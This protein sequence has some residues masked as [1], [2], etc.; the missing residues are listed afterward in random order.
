MTNGLPHR[1]RR[2]SNHYKH[3]LTSRPGTEEWFLETGQL[4]QELIRGAPQTREILETARSL[5][6]QIFLLQAIRQERRRLLTTPPPPKLYEELSKLALFEE[7]RHEILYGN[8]VK[9]APDRAW[10][11]TMISCAQ[12]RGVVNA[13][14]PTSEGTADLLRRQPKALQ[15]IDVYERKARSRIKKLINRLDYLVIEEKRKI[16]PA[17]D[18]GT[19]K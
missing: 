2:P 15:R 9:E 11:R 7:A 5:S 12:Y 6:G 3:G 8:F 14:V 17:S 10:A 4:A 1:R 13:Y 16:V 19:Q 18:A